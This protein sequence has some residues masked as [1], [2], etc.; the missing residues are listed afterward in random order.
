MHKLRT[1]LIRALVLPLA[2]LAGC[3]GG[4]P[5][6][7]VIPEEEF[8][9]LY[10]D[11]LTAAEGSIDTPS[12]AITAPAD[13]VLKRRGVTLEEYRNTVAWYNRDPE[14]WRG[15]FAEVIRKGAER[16]ARS[17]EDGTPTTS[18]QR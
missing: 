10:L 8:V 6:R 17:L 14:S 15:F 4:S 7:G 2:F 13:S 3:G 16:E 11:L 12:A 18:G 1:H 9:G 5:P